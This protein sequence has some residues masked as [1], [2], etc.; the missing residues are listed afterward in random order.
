MDMKY[1]T[2][3]FDLD[4]TLL[5]TSAGVIHAVDYI[6]AEFHLPVL[7]K[8][9]KYSFIGPPV[10]KSFQ[11]HYAC[12][13]EQAWKL[14]S[15]WRKAYKERFLLEAVPY[16]GIYDLLRYLRQKG[17]RT[18][19]ATNKREDYTLKMLEHF[20]FLPLFDFIVGSDMAGK[21]SKTDMIGLCLGRINVTDPAQALM[22]GDTTGDMTAAEEAGVDFLGVTYGFG[23]R[24]MDEEKG[25]HLA[26]TC[27][28]I[29]AQF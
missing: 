2:V 12:T 29:Q 23:F 18:C 19:V 17:I 21:R 26:G 7:S 8:E 9:E 27:Q 11:T 10:Q 5:D 1:Q 15:A 22:V 28:E 14:A 3:I 4:G 20:S 6:I 13:E 24:E 16:K 25:I